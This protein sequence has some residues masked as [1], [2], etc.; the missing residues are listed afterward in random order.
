ME[1]Q[2]SQMNKLIILKILFVSL[3]I[4]S[5]D[6]YDSRLIIKNNGKNDIIVAYD[7]SNLDT[8][9]K[10]DTDKLNPKYENVA[11]YLTNIISPNNQR[12][13]TKPGSLKSWSF[14]INKSINN[15]LNI[16]IIDADTLLKYNCLDSIIIKNLY[17]KY[18]FTETELN[19]Q[20]WLIDYPIK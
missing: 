6:Y 19:K 18:S 14:Y 16:F 8:T 9:M 3:I 5:C 20:R 2:V 15:K 1:I 12:R 11:Y 4:T 10:I 13:F 17:K 7:I